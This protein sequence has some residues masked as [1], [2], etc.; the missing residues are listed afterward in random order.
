MEAI[1]KAIGSRAQIPGMIEQMAGGL[2][3]RSDFAAILESLTKRLEALEAA[4]VTSAD[5]PTPKPALQSAAAK[6][7]AEKVAKAAEVADEAK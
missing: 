3:S 7:A 5:T 2:V 6:K 1:E 4:P